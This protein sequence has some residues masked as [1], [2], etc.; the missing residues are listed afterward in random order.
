M[1]SAKEAEA[2]PLHRDLHLGDDGRQLSTSGAGQDYSHTTMHKDPAGEEQSHSWLTRKM[3]FLRTR[4][5]K[6]ITVVVIL[7]V[8]GGG[9]AGLAALNKRHGRADLWVEPYHPS[10]FVT[11]DGYFY[12]QSPGV[13][14]SREFLP[15][16]SPASR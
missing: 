8:I 4:R 14:P 16:F 3:P 2:A 5:G 10:D 12:G 11:D 15:G 1:S 6:I 9:L 7:V 13:Y